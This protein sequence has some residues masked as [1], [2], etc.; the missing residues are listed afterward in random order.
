MK[1]DQITCSKDKNKRWTIPVL[2]F[3]L[4]IFF[5]HRTHSSL[6]LTLSRDKQKCWQ[7]LNTLLFTGFELLT[8]AS[9][10]RTIH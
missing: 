5:W 7:A 8:T 10:T 2:S 9:G 4:K 1:S 6:W 3:N